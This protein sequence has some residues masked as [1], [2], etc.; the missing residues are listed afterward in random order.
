M[1]CFLILVFCVASGCAMAIIENAVPKYS[2]SSTDKS[3]NCSKVLKDL[4]SPSATKLFNKERSQN[5]V[6]TDDK[7][8]NCSGTGSLF[9]SR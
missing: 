6:V 9:H 4:N 3:V 5:D 7:A 8:N 2:V 1:I